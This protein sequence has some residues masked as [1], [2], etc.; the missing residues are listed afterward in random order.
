MDVEATLYVNGQWAGTYN[1]K[2]LGKHWW[3]AIFNPRYQ[4]INK[5][6]ITAKY[7]I[8]MPNEQLYKDFKDSVDNVEKF[9][10]WDDE[11][12]SFNIIY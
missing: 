12:L 6:S 8:T 11:N 2:R 10:N 1:S 4:Y 9:S 5:E 3:P 7:R